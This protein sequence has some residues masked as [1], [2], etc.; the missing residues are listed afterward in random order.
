MKKL[1]SL[2]I[3]LV[4]FLSINGT[5]AQDVYNLWEGQKTPY[6]IENDL[7]EYVEEAYST[8][9]VFNITKPTLT[10]YKAKGGNTGKAVVII[11]GGGYSLV[12]MYHEGYDLAKVL[13]EKGITAA[14]LKYRLPH[15]KSSDKPHLVPIT[16]ARRALVLLRGKSDKYGFNIDKVGVM[17]FSA[18]SHLATVASL[19][20]SENSKEN[21]D[22]SAL[23]YGVTRLNEENLKWLEES[24]YYRKLTKE[25]QAKNKLLDL[26]SAETPPAFLVH[27]YDDDICN[28]KE[29]TLYA[30][31]LH[32][33][34]IPVEM[35]LFPKGGHGFGIGRKEDGTYQWV[36]LF[37]DWVKRNEF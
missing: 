9:C 10:V 12:A 19:W 27:S 34:K 30:E 33:N 35:H 25:E 24:L 8:Q 32:K 26:V 37:V 18:G 5:V 1:R 31:K 13:S 36:D 2:L 6:Y 29:S 11:P 16:D 4:S 7:K 23:I 28:I 22:F 20:K 15:P 14:V 17:G 3:T 21:P